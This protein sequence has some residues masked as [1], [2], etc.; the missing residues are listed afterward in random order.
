M[1]LCE[2]STTPAAVI[3]AIY[4]EQPFETA[5]QNSINFR[6]PCMKKQKTVTLFTYIIRLKNLH[7][8]NNLQQYSNWF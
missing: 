5:T 4:H 3:I 7:T 6:K 2:V 8:C 1:N